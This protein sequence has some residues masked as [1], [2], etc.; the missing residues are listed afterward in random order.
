MDT[1]IP[2]DEAP[3][4]P[5]K[6]ETNSENGK[7][8]RVTTMRPGHRISDT[9]LVVHADISSRTPPK[10]GD[11]NST[12]DISKEAN[13]MSSTIQTKLPESGRTW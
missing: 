1:G 9:D 11:D 3:P 10:I 5:F 13:S 6:D 8:I 4:S 2:E 12:T 7:E